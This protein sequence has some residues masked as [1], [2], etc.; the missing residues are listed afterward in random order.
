MLKQ[1]SRGISLN[2]GDANTKY[3][4]A[5]FKPNMKN[6]AIHSISDNN[7]EIVSDQS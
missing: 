4:Y 5:L 6:S 1:K 7:G 3:F 2:L